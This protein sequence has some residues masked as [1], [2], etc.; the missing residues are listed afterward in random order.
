MS[1]EELLGHGSW[2]GKKKRKDRLAK[3]AAAKAKKTQA[4]IVAPKLPRITKS[5]LD[6]AIRCLPGYDPFLE[7]GDCSFDYKRAREAVRFFHEELKHVKGKWRGQPLL[8][9]L[10]EIGIVANIFGWIRPDGLRRFRKVFIFVPRKNAKTT[11]CAGILNLILFEDGEPG[12]EIYGMASEHYQAC[13]IFEQAAGM[14]KQNEALS[15]RCRVYDGQAK[16]I[17]LKSDDSVYRVLSHGNDAR[18]K[19]G[20]NVHAAFIDEVHA[21]P[22]GDLVEALE[23]GTGAREQPLIVE[24]TTSDFDRE[25]SFCNEEYDYAVRVRDEGGDPS[26]LPVI[27]EAPKNCDWKDPKVWA[28]ANPNLGVSISYEA[29]EHECRT[30]INR[31]SKLNRFLRLHLNIRTAADTLWI[32]KAA[33]Q[34][35]AGEIDLEALKGRTCFGGLDLAS[36]RDITALVLMFPDGDTY[37]L[38]PFFWVPEVIGERHDRKNRKLYEKWMRQGVL[39]VTPGD[40]TDY[41]IILRDIKELGELYGIRDIAIDMNWQGAQLATDLQGAGFEVTKFGQSYLAFA[42]PTAEFEA[43]WSSGRLIHPNHPVLNWMA[44]NVSVQWNP[45]GSC[46][47]PVKD[48]TRGKID[49]IVAAIMALARA[50]TQEDSPEPWAWRNTTD[51]ESS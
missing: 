18:R 24:L 5:L 13:M 2:R 46:M 28:I 6:R 36:Y 49:A 38:L 4:K 9:E 10:W 14:V 11:L 27:Y 32:P 17:K 40:S 51:A 47:K 33:W 8:L 22:N 19:H 7:A 3:V 42:A 20:Y 41:N 44:E 15:E 37:K 1:E 39:R 35:C 29:L 50:M 21:L 45:E 48:R 12:A 26:F 16:A 34:K 23:T 43:L 30:A 31:P 25:G